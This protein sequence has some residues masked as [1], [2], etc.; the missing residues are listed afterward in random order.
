MAVTGS[1]SG[2]VRKSA[3]SVVVFVIGLAILA[4]AAKSASMR[5]ARSNEEA[6]HAVAS[7]K[8]ASALWAA[9][10]RNRQALRTYR[11]K[12]AAYSAAMDPKRIVAPEGAAQ[13]RQAIDRFRAACA[14]LDAARNASDMALLQQVDAS[15]AGAATTHEVREA[16]ERIDVYVQ[17]MRDNQRAQADALGRVVVFLSA[18]ADTLAFDHQG[19]VF[20]DPDD[21]ATYNRLAQA[22]RTLSSQ[23]TQLADSIEFATRN[24]F[25]DLARR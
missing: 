22:A 9:A 7:S 18:H 2:A 6:A 21:L 11:G 23:E 25:A 4:L 20:H 10:E 12:V 13:A 14:E 17:R 19:P 15:P 3:W 1:Q 24:E 5:E 16:L 8:V